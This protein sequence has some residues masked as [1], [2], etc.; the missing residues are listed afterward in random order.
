M[1]HI[2]FG[3]GAVSLRE[4]VL[5]NF[6]SVGDASV[7]ERLMM[8]W[9]SVTL[10]YWHPVLLSMQL[11]S[12]FERELE[13]RQSWLPSSVFPANTVVAPR[14]NFNPIDLWRSTIQVLLA[15]MALWTKD[16]WVVYRTPSPTFSGS[17]FF[18][19]PID[20]DKASAV[21]GYC[22]LLPKL[23]VH[24]QKDLPHLDSLV[25]LWKACLICDQ[26]LWSYSISFVPGKQ[27][28]APMKLQDRSPTCDPH[29]K[30]AE[31]A[32]I[33]TK[34]AAILFWYLSS[35][36][37]RGYMLLSDH[38]PLWSMTSTLWAAQRFG[39][40]FLGWR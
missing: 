39:Q 5:A 6:T 30:T 34:S 28:E 31:I 20:D 25:V 22:A 4:P 19:C 33:G 13:G 1:S 27:H 9:E 11:L 14:A 18:S 21:S 2:L 37:S 15:A 17:I 38:T 8:F 32:G 10:I 26:R 12:M 3:V 29:L 7:Y 36:S 35:C 40:T 23:K 24:K 16:V